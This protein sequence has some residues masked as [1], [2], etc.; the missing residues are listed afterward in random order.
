M[1]RQ[2]TLTL[3]L[4]LYCICRKESIMTVLWEALPAADWDWTYSPSLDWGQG[5]LWKSWRKDW[6]SWRGWQPH[7]KNNISTN[8]IPQS[9]QRLSHQR[10]YVDWPLAPGTYVAEALSGPVWPQ[11]KRI[12]LIL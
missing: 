7:R 5:S 12:C 1:G 9:S 6:R 3:L 10:A 11:W 2:Q 4:M 8:Q